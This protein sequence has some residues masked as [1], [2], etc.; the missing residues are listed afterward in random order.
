MSMSMSSQVK[1]WAHQESRRHKT[2]RPAAVHTCELNMAH[3]SFLPKVRY[4]NEWKSICT[5]MDV[6]SVS[7]SC[8]HVWIYITADLLFITFINMIDQ[9]I[10]ILQNRCGRI[11]RVTQHA[12]FTHMNDRLLYLKNYYC[13]WGINENHVNSHVLYIVIFIVYFMFKRFN[14]SALRRLLYTYSNH[15]IDA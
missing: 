1:S 6:I 2:L 13:F 3:L 10:V 8:M 7:W 14:F 15:K 4:Y 9:S 5:Q 12:E 11:R